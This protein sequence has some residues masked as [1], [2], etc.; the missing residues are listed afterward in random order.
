[1]VM[2]ESR[3]KH[4]FAIDLRSIAARPKVLWRP[5]QPTATTTP[6]GDEKP[7]AS[8]IYRI[9]ARLNRAPERPLFLVSA[10]NLAVAVP[11]NGGW[12]T[13]ELGGTGGAEADR[14]KNELPARSCYPQAR[15]S[16]R[17]GR[18]AQRRNVRRWRARA[19]AHLGSGDRRVC[20][21]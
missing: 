6:E 15:H 17:H 19:P 7:S 13:A 20:R 1:M 14:R 3:L 2:K 8:G 21:S 4:P 11:A 10:G 5:T 18:L 12:S 9:L 16:H